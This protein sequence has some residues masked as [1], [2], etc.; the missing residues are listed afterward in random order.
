MKRFFAVLVLSDGETWEV[1][2]GQS[3]IVIDEQQMNA[4][5]ND[6][7]DAKDIAPVVEIG[8]KDYTPFNDVA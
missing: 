6:E 2:D 4:L 5:A 8:L 7:I 1:L 3:I